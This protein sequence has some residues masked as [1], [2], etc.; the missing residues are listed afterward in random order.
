MSGLVIIRGNWA[1]LNINLLGKSLFNKFQKDL[2][3]SYKNFIDMSVENKLYLILKPFEKQ[4]KLDYSIIWVPRCYMFLRFND[5]KKAYEHFKQKLSININLDIS[6]PWEILSKKDNV[7]QLNFLNYTLTPEQVE[8]FQYMKDKYYRDSLIKS[9]QAGCVLVMPCG[10]GKTVMGCYMIFAIKKKT[11]W[12]T[13]N[14]ITVEQCIEAINFCLPYLTTSTDPLDVGKAD[15]VVT[16]VH[17]FVNENS[18]FLQ[19]STPEIKDN[20]GLVIYD[21]IHLLGSSV[22]GQIFNLFGARYQLGLTATPLERTDNMYYKYI[23]TVGELYVPEKIKAVPFNGR[24]LKIEYFNTH[25]NQ[26]RQFVYN[27]KKKASSKDIINTALTIKNITS[28]IGRYQALDKILE[29]TYT[30]HA[31]I[32]KAIPLEKNLIYGKDRRVPGVI[33]YCEYVETIFEV[34]HYLD[35][36]TKYR[37]LKV[38]RIMSEMSDH[39]EELTL[40]TCDII[41]GNRKLLTGVS[42]PRFTTLVIWTTLKRGTAQL[43]GRVCRFVFGNEDWNKLE[44]LVF[45]I[46]DIGA[47]PQFQYDKHRKLEYDNRRW[48]VETIKIKI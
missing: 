6:K 27:K 17:N 44:R 5:I 31:D 47:L 35:T 20:V 22:F 37:G 8:A 1:G 25:T 48:N 41:I 7:Q 4:N 28:D 19:S 24:V 46:T 36:S 30:K 43:L 18:R 26:F 10:T 23:Y 11:V 33:I 3:I 34:M 45:D 29:Y 40:K 21:E 9:G 38:G 14:N 42:L 2:T 32:I 16:T 12:I 13:N 15:V 39:E